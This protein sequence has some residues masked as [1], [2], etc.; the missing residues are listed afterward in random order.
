MKRVK[1]I[2]LVNRK[3]GCGKTT[4]LFS[5]AGV[6]ACEEKKKVFV[7]DLDAQRNTT[8]TMLMN[9]GDEQKPSK[10]IM[11]VLNGGD[12]EDALCSAIWQPRGRRDYVKYSVDVLSGDETI[13]AADGLVS[14]S[15]DKLAEAGSRIND[16]IN[17]NG[18]DW[19]LVDMPP[20]SKAI[21]DFCFKYLAD[22]MLCPF[23]PDE[24]S[25]N[26]YQQLLRDLEDARVVNSKARIVG[27]F[28]NK[29]DYRFSLHK[30]LDEEL[31]E[32]DNYICDVPYES[33][34]AESTYVGRPVCLYKSMSKGSRAY[35]KIVKE[36]NYR[37]KKYDN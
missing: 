22:Y 18:Y 36:M 9:V 6:L 34:I 29:K 20:S 19:V 27:I 1:R 32:I 13:D 4:S 23:S 17:S 25:A 5:I 37:I 10:T 30:Q 33:A 12:V 28:M 31:S 21:N 15:E 14:I 16:Y 35:R 8:S 3:G 26:G 24:Y 7:I 2:A 11:D